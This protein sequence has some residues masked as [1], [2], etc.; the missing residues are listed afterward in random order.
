MDLILFRKKTN[1][2]ELAKRLIRIGQLLKQGY[3]MEAA[4]SFIALHVN[5]QAQE[6][7]KNVQLDLQNGVRIH[8]AFLHLELPADILSFIYFY[9][10]QGEVAEGL[11]Q[12]G[13]VFEGR[14]K[15]KV[16]IHK[17]LRYPLVL[18]LAGI[19]VLVIVQQFIV[20]H[21]QKLFVSMD[22]NPPVLTA[23]FFGFL[24][25]LPLLVLVLLV[26]IIGLYIYYRTKIK[27]LS[28]HVKINK[29]LKNRIL[30]GFTRRILTYYFS[31][32]LGRLL[33]GGMSIQNALSVFEQQTH[34]PFFQHEAVLMKAELQQGES[35]DQMLLN[36]AYFSKD[37]SFVVENGNRTGYMASDLQ[38]YSQILFADLEESLKKCL[39][40]L[41][42][43]FFI[44]MGGFI[45]VVFLSVMLPMFEMI[46]ALR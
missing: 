1:K 32:Q 23:F 9:E 17:L 27:P 7:L 20:P 38:N 43:V 21:F 18:G 45:F 41:Q 3:S 36:R 5:E 46:G 35:L 10:E 12:A 8:E 19:M 39:A 4:L 25:N 42:P 6:Q 30:S 44:G 29:L 31:L 14:E 28:A 24:E 22:S 33:E 11:I 15:T 26:I 34:L 13:I 2:L 40:L 37:L 16:Q